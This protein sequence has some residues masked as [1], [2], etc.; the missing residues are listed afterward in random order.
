MSTCLF[1][2]PARNCAAEEIIELLRV[3]AVYGGVYTT[4]QL[5]L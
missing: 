2:P 3:V 5:Q 4:Q 1:Y